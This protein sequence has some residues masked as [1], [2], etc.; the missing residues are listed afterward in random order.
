MTTPD[1]II[2]ATA[3]MQDPPLATRNVKD[4]DWIGGLRV[5]DPL[6]EA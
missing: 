6:A 1:A 4:F 3:V 2:A 5:V